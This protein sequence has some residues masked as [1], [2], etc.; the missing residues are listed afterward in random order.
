MVELNK[1]LI[2]DFD[3]CKFLVGFQTVIDVAQDPIKSIGL[4]FSFHLLFTEQF[5]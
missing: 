4:F 5:L 3:I 2:K 1:F